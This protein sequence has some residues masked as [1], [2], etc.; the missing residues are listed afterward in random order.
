FV[1]APQ[2]Q[3]ATKLLDLLPEVFGSVY[4][5][6]SGAEATEG[7]MKIAK[8][9]TGRRQIIAARNAYHGSTQGALSLIGN[10]DYHRVYAP[11]LPEIDF[12]DYN[13]REDLSIIT[14]QTAA[15]IVEAIQGEAGVRVPD[16]AYMQALRARCDETGA[17]LI[18][19]E[20]QTG[21]GRTGRMFAFE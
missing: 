20:I 10:P 9:F 7:A 4:L 1:Q 18:F 12:I 14:S 8:K 3:L 2:V 11:L 21:M 6:N 19:D 5:T 16:A 17:L 13:V 15:V